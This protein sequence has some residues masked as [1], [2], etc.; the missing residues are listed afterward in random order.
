MAAPASYYLPAKAQLGTTVA[1][2]VKADISIF[3]MT[4]AQLKERLY[5]DYLSWVVHG[6]VKGFIGGCVIGSDNYYMHN[7]NR[8]WTGRSTIVN[9]IQFFND[10]GRNTL[11]IG[12]SA[13]NA[14]HAYSNLIV[15]QNAVFKSSYHSNT[16]G[17]GFEFR[18]GAGAWQKHTMPN[19][20]IQE[21]QEVSGR[22]VIRKSPKLNE[23][24]QYQIR[25]FL[26]NEEGIYNF[27]NIGFISVSDY[28]D[29]PAFLKRSSA[30][31]TAGQTQIV[32]F[33]ESLK[34]AQLPNLTTTPQSGLGLFAYKDDVDF[35]ELDTAWYS[36]GQQDSYFYSKGVGFTHKE[37][38]TIGPTIMLWV[39]VKVWQNG[40]YTIDAVTDQAGA[41]A[42]T[43]SGTV[44]ALNSAGT[45]VA[46]FPV[47]VTIAGGQL[48]GTNSGVHN[49]INPA[50][51]ANWNVS[52][53]PSGRGIGA[54][55]VLAAAHSYEDS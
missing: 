23:F 17:Y 33:M 22:M 25:V 26:E 5:L 9:N 49:I 47:N 32:G 54:V 34:L 40:T 37:V 13:F 4:E 24:T 12:S 35:V 30:C 16:F 14:I 6:G 29:N 1:N 20:T 18:L 8:R 28:L 52:G 19:S 45:P 10:A 7:A 11:G 2:S 21:R 42:V 38:C 15:I 53:T 51:Y 55:N 27:G 39:T 3:D 44:Q 41:G 46:S 50:Q 31:A 36:E 43:Y 48:S